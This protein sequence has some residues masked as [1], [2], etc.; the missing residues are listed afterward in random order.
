MTK[1]KLVKFNHKAPY[2]RFRKCAISFAVMLGLSVSVAVP[3][4]ISITNV[5]AQEET[6][7]TIST[8]QE[9]VTSNDLLT[10]EN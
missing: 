10:S 6:S 9:D 3:V 8:S 4:S 2:Y 5:K 7:Q 1:D